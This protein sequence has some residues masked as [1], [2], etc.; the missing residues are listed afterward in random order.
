MGGWWGVV[1][2]HVLRAP[3]LGQQTSPPIALLKLKSQ[4]NTINSRFPFPKNID[5]DTDI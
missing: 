1:G 5:T 3:G 4:E 2:H